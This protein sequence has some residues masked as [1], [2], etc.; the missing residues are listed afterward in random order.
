MLRNSTVLR[1]VAAAP[2]AAEPVRAA[3]GSGHLP[4]TAFVLSGGASLGAAQAGMLQALYERG[5]VPD[6]LVGTSAGALNAAFVA[7]RPQTA[8]TA[9]D[10]ARIWRGIQRE[11]IFPLRMSALVSGACGRRDHTV[12]DCGLRQLVSQHIEFEDLADAA[13]PVYLVAFDLTE[14]R[15]LLLGDGPA[16]DA[17]VA[18]AS[19]PGVFPAVRMAERRLI[20][21]GVVNNTPISHAVELGA[22]RVYVLPTQDVRRQ[23]GHVPT[24]AL[25]A[26][27]YGLGLLMESRLR[28]DIERYSREVELIVLPPPNLAGTQP[29]SFEHSARLISKA[30]AGA[31]AML[32]PM[33]GGEH[34]RLAS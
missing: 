33:A 9:R 26:A 30:R 29:T 31:R 32:G 2:I 4:R 5:I 17:V 8:A 6:L 34:L 21:G 28:I 14:G 22:E 13:I 1:A 7:S 24:S 27:T 16:T 19:I 10:L 18:S 11:D 20:D 3:V 23:G 15:E 12:S 25:D